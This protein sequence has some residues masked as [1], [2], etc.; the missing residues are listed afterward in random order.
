[1]GSLAHLTLI[2]RSLAREI[3]KLKES[4]ISFSLGNE[5]TLLTCVQVKSLLIDDT[6]AKQY[7]DI[8]LCKIRDESIVNKNKDITLDS[9]GVL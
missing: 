7:Q 5:S 1:M 3:H 6:K 4:G 9:H 2:R 8:W